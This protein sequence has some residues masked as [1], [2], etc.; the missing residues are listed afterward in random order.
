[1]IKVIKSAF[2]WAVAAAICIFVLVFNSGAQT[3]DG[4]VSESGDYCAVRS[5]A[6]DRAPAAEGFSDMWSYAVR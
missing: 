3:L 1:M 4:E 6:W 5:A 2:P